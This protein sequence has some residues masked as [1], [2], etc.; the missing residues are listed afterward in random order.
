MYSRTARRERAPSQETMERMQKIFS[1][2]GF[3]DEFYTDRK[4]ADMVGRREEK[5][6]PDSALFTSTRKSYLNGEFQ[7][8]P[9]RF[10]GSVESGKKVKLAAADDQNNSAVVYGPIPEQAFHKEFTITALKTQLHKTSGTPFVC[11]GVKG[12]VEPGLTLPT[13]AF[14]D[15]RQEVFAE[16]LEQ[17]KPVTMR[18]E[19]EYIPSGVVFEDLTPDEYEIKSNAPTVFTVSV[20]K[21]DQLSEE[22]RELR[23]KVLYVPVTELE[24]DS[25]ILQSFLEDKSIT[26]SVSLPRFIHDN[27]KKRISRVLRRAESLGVRDALISNIGHIQFAKSHGMSVRGEFGLNVYNSESLHVLQKLGLKSATLSFE[28]RLAEVRSLLKPIDTELITYGRLPLMITESCIVRNC[29]EACTCD[30]FAGLVGE[31]GALYPVVPDFGCRNILLNSKKLFMADKRRS[32]STL[33][34]WAQRL[35]FT[36]ENSIE[37]VSIMRRYM[38]KGNF[39]PPGFT[40][41]LYFAGAPQ[42]Q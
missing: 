12:I 20:F 25:S 18:E 24:Y 14:I 33:G 39:S 7:R 38:E 40:R 3:T 42:S 13:S 32:T 15:L 8:V 6:N 34:L 36:T 10:V 9:I 41:G 22:L 35:Y 5:I 37:C 31:N 21:A 28:L 26:V 19:G 16:I 30:S 23:P 2:Q 27:E 29:T 11:L 17:R 1:R 4:S